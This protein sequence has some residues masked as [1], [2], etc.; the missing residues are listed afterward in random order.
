MITAVLVGLG[1]RSVGYASYADAN[2]G[3]LEIVAIAEP[4]PIRRS[5]YAERFGIDGSH[6]SSFHSLKQGSV[7]QLVSTSDFESGNPGSSPGRTSWCE[8]PVGPDSPKERCFWRSGRVRFPHT[9]HRCCM[10][11]IFTPMKNQDVIYF[12]EES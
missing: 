2:P 7:V 5:R 1:H 12:S 10:C 11:E 3:E 8:I 4:D 9:P 6:C